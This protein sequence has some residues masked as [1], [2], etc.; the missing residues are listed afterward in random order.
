MIYLKN[1]EYDFIVKISQDVDISTL[2]VY[3]VIYDFRKYT[4]VATSYEEALA[5]AGFAAEDTTKYDAGVY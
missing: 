1:A 2:T 5:V 3:Y 4:I